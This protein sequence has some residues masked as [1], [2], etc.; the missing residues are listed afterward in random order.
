MSLMKRMCTPGDIAEA[1]LFHAAGGAM[2]P[3]QTLPVDGGL[4]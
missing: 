3:G 4:I 1:I 2:I